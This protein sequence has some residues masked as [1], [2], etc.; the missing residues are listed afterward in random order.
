MAPDEW[1]K[2]A[3]LTHSDL[4]RGWGM[5]PSTIW[6]YTRGMRPPPM[7]VIVG[8]DVRSKGKVRDRDWARLYH[9]RLVELGIIKET[10]NGKGREA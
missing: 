6:R 8:F 1:L 5:S 3:G 2:E 7:E 4:A 10:G 9:H